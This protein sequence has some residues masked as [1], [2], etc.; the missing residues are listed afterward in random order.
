MGFSRTEKTILIVL[1]LLILILLLLSASILIS[2]QF[3][4]RL[5]D[6]PLSEPD[7]ITNT[8]NTN[9][10]AYISELRTIPH[11]ILQSFY[12]DG[13]T[14]EIS[15][16]HIKDLGN[17]FADAK[18]ATGA[19]YYA[20]KLICVSNPISVVHEMG[21][22]LN[23]SLS[24]PAR[25]DELYQMEANSAARVLGAYA[26]TNSREYFAEYFKVWILRHD[27]T[28]VMASL[29]DLS[30]QTYLYFTELELSNWNTNNN[31]SVRVLT[32][33]YKASALCEVQANIFQQHVR[34][35]IQAKAFQPRSLSPLIF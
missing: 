6:D 8:E 27:D 20:Q 28:D 16:A 11:S 14:F 23:Y 22:Y 5:S 30:P 13:W 15:S 34:T 26:T 32:R 25:V 3:P 7:L 29:R 24:F 18:G 12:E 31:L 17:I 33:L 19:T 35:Q 1:A 4:I 21:H 2:K 9:T 10:D